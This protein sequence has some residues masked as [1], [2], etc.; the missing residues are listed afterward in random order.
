MID[1]SI[2]F[3]EH[4]EQNPGWL[5]NLAPPATL[6]CC[7]ALEHFEIS[8]NLLQCNQIGFIEIYTAL[9]KFSLRWKVGGM[10]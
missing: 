4:L 8:D 9:K 6:A 5:A 3:N 10:L 2:N 7:Q 1:L